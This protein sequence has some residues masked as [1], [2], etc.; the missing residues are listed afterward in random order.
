MVVEEFIKLDIPLFFKELDRDINLI[1]N[2][3][4]VEKDLEKVSFSVNTSDMNAFQRKVG[5]VFID[6]IEY[7]IANLN[8][9]GEDSQF[10]NVYKLKDGRIMMG[11]DITI[12]VLNECDFEF[13]LVVTRDGI[14][15]MID[16]N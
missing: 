2:I 14:S 1:I 7:C 11:Y 3:Y 6:K 8:P 4:N 12:D 9:H 5:L 15:Y 10:Y 13:E 16:I